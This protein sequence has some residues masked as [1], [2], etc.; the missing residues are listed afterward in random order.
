VFIREIGEKLH[1]MHLLEGR[2]TVAAA[3]GAVRQMQQYR[4]QAKEVNDMLGL[5][6]PKM[7]KTDVN[8]VAY[9]LFRRKERLC[10]ELA[11]A[12]KTA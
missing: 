9:E 3:N 8:A 6:Q 2:L 11:K 5:Q 4:L 12:L 10:E 7:K 1:E